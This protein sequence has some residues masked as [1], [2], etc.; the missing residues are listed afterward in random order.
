MPGKLQSDRLPIIRTSAAE[1]D[2]IASGF[3]SPRT[4]R[5][6]P[7]KHCIAWKRAG[8]FLND[9]RRPAPAR[10]DIGKNVR[11]LVEGDYIVFYRPSEESI[12]IVRVLHT[13]QR[14]GRDILED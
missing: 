6:R 11:Q 10:D 12:E 14:Q 7:T 9:F 4:I 3:V 5:G 2:L 13:R 1:E 8:R